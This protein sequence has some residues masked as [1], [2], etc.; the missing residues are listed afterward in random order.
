V[1][2]QIAAPCILKFAYYAIYYDHYNVQ[3]IQI[4]ILQ[5]FE[6]EYD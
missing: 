6:K 2:S 4:F 3:P 1:L 5:K